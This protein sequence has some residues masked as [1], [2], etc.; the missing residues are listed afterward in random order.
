LGV[1]MSSVLRK[2]F[3]S[4][5]LWTALALTLLLGG[6]LGARLAFSQSDDTPAASQPITAPD[7]AALLARGKYLSPA[8]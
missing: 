3:A 8:A 1:G 5:G 2:S 7:Q 4:K 6:A